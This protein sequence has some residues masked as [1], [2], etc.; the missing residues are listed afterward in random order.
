MGSPQLLMDMLKRAIQH[1]PVQ[2]GLDDPGSCY[3]IWT[4]SLKNAGS[5]V[6]MAPVLPMVHS[7]RV[8]CVCRWDL[9]YNNRPGVS[10]MMH[11][12]DTINK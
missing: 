1:A 3:N 8:R 9:H 6:E 2:E 10:L 4:L 7:P 12:Q 11:P 5:A